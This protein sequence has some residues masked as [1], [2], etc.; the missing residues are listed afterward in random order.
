MAPAPEFSHSKPFA[1][2]R[3][4]N[5]SVLV[6]GRG[7]HRLLS[8][9]KDQEDPRSGGH[10]RARLVIW[11]APS[12]ASWNE[13]GTIVTSPGRV[14]AGDAF[15]ISVQTG[16]IAPGKTRS[17]PKFLPGGKHLLYV[18]PASSGS[19]LRAYAAELATGRETEL[20][21]TDT[22]VTFTPDQP[23]S[24]QGHLLFGRAATLL[25]VRFDMRGLRVLGEPSPVAQNV[26]FMFGVGWS[27]F[28]DYI[29]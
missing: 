15:V 24:A 11:I 1:G 27:E 25:A 5:H 17:W 21:P 10:T 28:Y 18:N 26:P 23:G 2:N 16:A 6:A 29:S 7:I 4:R 20:M 12:S 9:R 22:Q 13:D 14:V 19:G 8:R 3:R